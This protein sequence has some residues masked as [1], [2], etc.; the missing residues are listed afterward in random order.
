M[1]TELITA[2]S[3]A[4]MPKR[5]HLSL[6]SEVSKGSVPARQ[7]PLKAVAPR[8]QVRLHP[9]GCCCN[10]HNPNGPWSIPL[11][12]NNKT[13]LLSKRPKLVVWD[14]EN[15]QGNPRVS[16]LNVARDFRFCRSVLGLTRQDY[17]IF[18]MSHF[19]A[20]RCSFA[21]PTN[22]SA[23]VIGSGPDGADKALIEAADLPRLSQ[24]YGTLV[25]VSNDHIFTDLARRAKTFGLTTWHVSTDQ[26]EWGCDTRAA[27]D[28]WTH[29]KLNAV[30]ER[31]KAQAQER[32]ERR[33]AAA[34]TK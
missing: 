29:I 12:L 9:K 27:Y 5:L 34:A 7:R 13:A 15:W 24:H 31:A 6:V 4:T 21:L 8:H 16:P 17:V 32:A 2:P 20:K 1:S 11:S 22:Q 28:G 14:V 10:Y 33:R 26:S 23:L 25:V 18:G 30:R 3:P 19:T